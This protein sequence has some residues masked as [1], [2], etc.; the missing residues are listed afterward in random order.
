MNACTHQTLAATIPT[1]KVS[2]QTAEAARIVLDWLDR[3]ASLQSLPAPQLRTLAALASD[4][5]ETDN[6]PLPVNRQPH[7][8]LDFEPIRIEEPP[9]FRCFELVGLFALAL[10]SIIAL[11]FGAR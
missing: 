4:G 6:R 10:V 9:L 8:P 5:G 3:G 11:W 2:T 1:A 7:V